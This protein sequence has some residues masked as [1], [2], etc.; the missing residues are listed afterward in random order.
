MIT[1]VFTLAKVVL[2]ISHFTLTALGGLRSS[3]T[4]SESLKEG[5]Q[6]Y[7][8]PVPQSLSQLFTQSRLGWSLY[9]RSEVLIPLL[10]YTHGILLLVR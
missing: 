2:S 6:V 5:V 9:F 10:G 7:I 8:L 3:P 1:C 4:P